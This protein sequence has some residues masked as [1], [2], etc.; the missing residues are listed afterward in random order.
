MVSEERRTGNGRATRTRA[1]STTVRM[2]V[3]VEMGRRRPVSSTKIAK[4]GG[5]SGGHL[6]GFEALDQLRL[7][8]EGPSAST[9]PGTS[10]SG[11]A[12]VAPVRV[13]CR[14]TPRRAWRVSSAAASPA[15][16]KFTMRVAL[17]TNPRSW[18]SSSLADRW[19]D[20]GRRQST[21]ERVT[22]IGRS[23]ALWARL[24]ARN[25]SRARVIAPPWINLDSRAIR[26]RGKS[27]SSTSISHQART[28]AERTAP[29]RSG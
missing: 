18:A 17:V 10:S 15:A 12:G 22:P 29:G 8:R 20:R 28:G 21:I 2:V 6:S 23:R 9:R 1:S 16:G 26:A 13:T 3:T 5:G 25:S 7:A 24:P 4:A 27:S 11:S 19:S 14:P